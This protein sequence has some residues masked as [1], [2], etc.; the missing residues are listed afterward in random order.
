MASNDQYVK[1]LIRAPYRRHRVYGAGMAFMGDRR[2]PIGDPLRMAILALRCGVFPVPP[3][4][5][6]GSE[7]ACE[8]GTATPRTWRQSQV[9][10]RPMVGQEIRDCIRHR[11][12]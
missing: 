11:Q 10:N 12:I 3:S 6:R 8:V 5:D 1:L 4:K 9:T 2:L 7:F